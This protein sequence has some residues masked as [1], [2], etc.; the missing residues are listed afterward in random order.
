MKRVICN[1]AAKYKCCEG[2]RHDK[3]HDCEDECVRDDCLVEIDEHKEVK[4]WCRE[5]SHD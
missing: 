1:R 5:A 4:V 2:C 3:P